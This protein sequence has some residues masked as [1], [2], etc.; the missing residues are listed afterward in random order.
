MTWIRANWKWI[1]L[2]TV[3]AAVGIQV[4]FSDYNKLQTAEDAAAFRTTL[5]GDTGSAFGA[6]AC[7]MAF[8]VGYSLLALVMCDVAGRTRLARLATGLALAGGLMDEI[9]NSILVRNIG[10]HKTIDNDAIDVM[11]IPGTIKWIGT[12][13]F[14]ILFGLLIARR[15]R[16]ND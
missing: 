14:L 10:S 12:P 2:F 5:G 7:D 3:V 6:T 11:Q 1:L 4:C 13:G 9:E 8:A 16:S 15:F